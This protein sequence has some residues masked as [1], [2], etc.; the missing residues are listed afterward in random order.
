MAEKKLLDQ[1]RDVIRTKHYSYKTEKSYVR[2]I[3]QY[4][5]F[6][7]K[8]HPQDMGEPEIAAFLTYLATKQNVSATTQNQALN[9]IVFLCK[10]VLHKELG[11][12]QHVQWAKRPQRLPV[13]LTQDEVRRVLLNLSGREKIMA[14]ILYGAGLRLMECLRLRVKDIDFAARQICIR[15]G[16]GDKDRMTMLPDAIIKELQRHLEHVKLLHAPDLHP[17]PQS[18]R[19]RRTQP[20]R[21]PEIE[22]AP[23]S[24]ACELDCAFTT[25]R[26]LPRNSIFLMLQNKSIECK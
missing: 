14:S 11:T 22:K 20:P 3:L 5:L 6:H 4:I 15:S 9:A 1:V 10:H 13:V 7:H 26:L 18:R 12:F 25:M 23:S 16:K 2:W 17:C 24:S 8:C 21:C 19:I